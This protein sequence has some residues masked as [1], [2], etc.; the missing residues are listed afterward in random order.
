MR[1]SL[2]VFWADVTA[3]LFVVDISSY[4]VTGPDGEVRDLESVEPFTGSMMHR[5][6][7]SVV[8]EIALYVCSIQSCMYLCL[9]WY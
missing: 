2:F 5:P 3:F 9:I 8:I 6:K 4:D 1:F 7:D